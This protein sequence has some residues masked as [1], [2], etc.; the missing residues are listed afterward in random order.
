MKPILSAL[1]TIGAMLASNANAQVVYDKLGCMFTLNGHE[2]ES[3]KIE[4]SGDGGDPLYQTGDQ[5]IS[6]YDRTFRIRTTVILSSDEKVSALGITVQEL[7]GSEVLWAQNASFSQ[8]GSFDSNGTVSF[9]RYLDA[10]NLYDFEFFGC[11][12]GYKQK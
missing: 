11:A 9:H 5:Q 2:G 4:T 3:F 8:A 1:I 10:T 12:P 7:S 6:L